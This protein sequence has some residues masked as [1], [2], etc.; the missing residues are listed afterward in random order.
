MI[1][2]KEKNRLAS[3]VFW[4][5]IKTGNVKQIDQKLWAFFGQSISLDA[6]VYDTSEHEH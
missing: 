6:Y 4:E 3:V 1:C 2:Q 5:E